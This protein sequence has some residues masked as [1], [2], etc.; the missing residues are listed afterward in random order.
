L[1]GAADDDHRASD[2]SA[3]AAKFRGP[4]HT[5]KLRKP[6]RACFTKVRVRLLGVTDLMEPR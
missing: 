3:V 4:E 6:V 5:A 2:G 1:D